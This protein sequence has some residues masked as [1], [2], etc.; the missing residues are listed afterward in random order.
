MPLVAKLQRGSIGLT[1]GLLVIIFL[2]V[3]KPQF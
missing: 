3:V 2:M 1:I